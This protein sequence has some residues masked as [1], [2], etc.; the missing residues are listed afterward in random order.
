MYSQPAQTQFGGKI[1]GSGRRYAKGINEAE[2]DRRNESAPLMPAPAAASSLYTDSMASWDGSSEGQTSSRSRSHASHTPRTTFVDRPFLTDTAT[3]I[4]RPHTLY[5]K[6]TNS[7]DAF[8]S[9]MLCAVRKC[10]KMLSRIARSWSVITARRTAGT[11]T[12]EEYSD[13]LPWLGPPTA[14]TSIFRCDPSRIT[15]TPTTRP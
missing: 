5:P 9:V 1:N 6:A 3:S 4:K 2:V 14:T 7:F 11:S 15:P 13:T 8:T 12:C 10:R